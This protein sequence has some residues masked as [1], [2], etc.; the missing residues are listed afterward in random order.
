M[1]KNLINKIYEELNTPN[2]ST[3]IILCASQ[4]G[5]ICCLTEKR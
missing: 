3:F 2:V 4:F 5:N 1:I